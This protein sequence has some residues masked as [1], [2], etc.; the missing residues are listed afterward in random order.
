MYSRFDTHLPRFLFIRRQTRS[1]AAPPEKI[2]VMI[3]GMKKN[4][5]YP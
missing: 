1:K 2:I 5:V 3:P 4:A